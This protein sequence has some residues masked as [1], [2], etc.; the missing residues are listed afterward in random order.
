MNYNQLRPYITVTMM[1]VLVLLA[2]VGGI[3][4]FAPQGPDSRHWS[5]LGLN[6][7]Q[8]K[9]IHLC[10]GVLVIIL[11]AIH[12]FL[13]FSSINNYLK[14]QSRVWTHPLL[15]A[16]VVIFFTVIIALLL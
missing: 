7:H 2:T 13:N 15:W 12:G 5:F 11:A 16:I 3:L 14:N 9:D 6:K 10:L 4:Y 1:I 8:F